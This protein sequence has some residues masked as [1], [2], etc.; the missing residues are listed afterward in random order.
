MDQKKNK[1]KADSVTEMKSQNEA[2]FDDRLKSQI[3][4]EPLEISRIIPGGKNSETPQNEPAEA[5]PTKDE[6]PPVDVEN[7]DPQ[8]NKPVPPK[9]QPEI[10]TQMESGEE[11][12]QNQ[13]NQPDN[14]QSD[15]KD[16]KDD[17]NEDDSNQPNVRKKVT[18]QVKEF[19]LNK[20]KA[21]A[22]WVK[23]N[24]SKAGAKAAARAV[25]AFIA[26][27]WPYI[28]AVLVIIFILI[29][30]SSSCSKT[31]GKTPIHPYDKNTDK[32]LVLKVLASSGDQPSQRE[33]YIL[34]AKEA[35]N[36][37][38]NIS[39]QNSDAQKK[40]D[41]INQLLDEIM[42]LSDSPTAMIEKI[43]QIIALLDQLITLLPD[44]TTKIDAIKT[45]VANIQKM[46]DLYKNP[47]L[48]LNPKDADYIR[49]FE[50][51]RRIGQ[52]LLY[53][54][55]PVDQ[56]G[57]GHERLKVKR[58]KF[59]YDTEN[60]SVSKETDYS[61]EDEPNISAHFT[62]QAADIVEIDN[63][64]CVQIKRRRVGRSKKTNLPP[65]PIKVSWQSE[66]GYLRD[67]GP[68]AYGQNMHQVF[69]NLS[70][71]AIDDVL[72][73]QLSD[74]LG[75]D[76]DPEKIKGKTFPEISR[77][78][79]Q[80]VLKETLGIPGDYKIG[81]NL[82][83][84]A[85]S[86]GRAY[87]ANAMGVPI[88]GI[89]GSTPE[90]ISENI[91]RASL[92]EKM[93]LA[94]GSLEGNNTGE[95]F[96]SA[97]RRLME[98]SLGLSRNTF[99]TAFSDSSSFRKVIGQGKTEASL[100]LKPQTFYGANISEVKTRIGKSSYEETFANP[101]SIDNWLGI[102]TG[103]TEK[104]TLGQISPD[105]YNQLVGNHLYDAQI[106]IY[107][108]NNKRAEVFGVQEADLDALTNGNQGV[109]VSMGKTV[110]SQT[111]TASEDERVLLRQWFDTG[112]RDPKL[113]DDYI[114]GQY[115]LKTGD[116]ADIFINSMGN[117]VF[118]RL[119]RIK[120][121][122][123]LSQNSTSTAL[124]DYVEVVQD[125]VFYTDRLNLI[126][127]DLRYLE[128]ES[129][130][131]EVR[132]KAKETR[133]LVENL[134]SSASITKIKKDIKQIQAN[135]K[136][137]E[138]KGAK[139]DPESAV[140]IKEIKK[141]V[142]EIIEGK[143]IDD[144]DSLD[145]GT[146]KAKTDPQVKLTKKDVIAIL[147][148]KK[149]VDDLVY[150]IGLRK[151][152]I[153]LDLPDNSL[154]TAY[155][156]L[157]KT[158]FKEA[159]ETTLISIG[160]TRLAE[161]GGISGRK[162][163]QVDKDLN[164]PAG[165]TQAYKDKKITE[166]AYHRK[167]GAGVTNNIAAK[168]LNK[169]LD[170]TN[171]PNYTLNGGDVTKLLS[172]GWFY[173]ALKVGGRGIDEAFSFPPGGTMDIITQTSNPG[174]VVGMIAEK[175]LGLLA[176]LNRSVSINGN[177]S[178]NLGRVKIEQELGLEPNEL[179]DD[180]LVDRIKGYTG[181]D[182]DSLSQLDMAFGLEPSTSHALIEGLIDP[183][184]YITN[185]GI[186]VRDNV[187]YQQIQNYAPALRN[188][189][190]KD[191]VLA[192]ASKTGTP[193][194]I[195]ASAGATQIGQV[196][197]LDY[198]VSIRGNFKDNLG[199]AKVENR[200]GLLKDSFQTDIDSVIALNGQQK[201][202][203]AF[204]ID[205]GELYNAR[206]GD[207]G[208][209]T[210]DRIQN[211]KIVDAILNIPSGY[212]RSFIIGAI[213]LSNYVDQVGKSS[214]TEI[215]ADKLVD[216]FE[217]DDKYK[218]A[219][220]TLVNTLN[221]D[222]DLDS[223][224][225]KQILLGALLTAG[226]WNLD[227]MTRFDPGTWEKI[228]FIDPNDPENTG[229]KNGTKIILEQGKKY[230]PKWMGM[231]EKYEPYIDMIYEQGLEYIGFGQNIEQA[232]A[233]DIKK[234]TG[235]PDNNDAL[236][237]TR[238]D[239][240]GGFTAWGAAQ[241]TASYNKE[242][243]GQADAPKLDYYTVKTAYFNDPA[244][245]QAIG[246]SAVE[247]ARNQPDGSYLTPDIE[248]SIR[249]EAIRSARNNARTNVQY[250][251]VDMQLHKQD[252]NVPAGFTKAMREGNSEARWDMGLKY[253]GNVIHSNNSAIPSE[254][255]P[256]LQDYFIDH[257][258][259]HLSDA[260]YAFLDNFMSDKFGDFIQPGTAKALV[261][262]QQT[263]NFGSINDQGSL[264]QIYA[265]YGVDIVTNWAD[266]QTSLPTGTTKLA[267]DYFTK[268]KTAVET[269][270]NAVTA[271]N[272]AQ[273]AYDAAK[274]TENAKA[275]N[276]AKNAA[277]SS[278]NALNS[279]KANAISTVISYAFQKQLYAAD[280]QLGLVPGSSAMLVGMGVSAWITGAVSPWT[281]ALFVATNLFG[282]YRIDTVCSACGSYP[283]VS[284]SEFGFVGWQVGLVPG[285]LAADQA[286]SL[287]SSQTCPLGNFDGQSNE[288][289]KTNAMAAAQ[290][291]TNQ[292]ISD[293]LQMG[294][295]LKDENLV[296]T[297]IMTYRQDDVDSNAG[298]L[299]ELYG[300]AN[301]RGNSGLWANEL[302]WD[303]VHIGY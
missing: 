254:L 138:D 198:A 257:N 255:L 271:L 278:T 116:F 293:V 140:K 130:S 224:Q 182:I 142:N 143:V 64:K 211:S 287:N 197:G 200:L 263:G 295:V 114:G 277:T 73:D 156:E 124:N 149:S 288:A 10:D 67:G 94:P 210:D 78:I 163:E 265:D 8:M 70:S 12:N 41:E 151:W 80:A 199:A 166:N 2:E 6:K 216:L 185:T 72:I 214:M 66:E 241:I 28:L 144:F 24:V 226:G 120:L 188:K 264:T 57:A 5:A 61:D 157:K 190:V 4:G 266:K 100:G 158:D 81:G 276:D 296:P 33:L 92:E 164:L 95:V 146:I 99:K 42:T 101:E 177:I 51:D 154:Q 71:G 133:L 89:Q 111:A 267:Y 110:I 219:V 109:F 227:N 55:T 196:L 19:Y 179:N 11:N 231:E 170:L 234:V 53:L 192:L 48:I 96:A 245:E 128:N 222:S 87:L 43:K 171:D 117:E 167:I 35:K 22:D 247:Y 249:Q 98:E 301:L 186:S 162:T 17:Q 297:Q 250:S 65:T 74:I 212:T 45:E 303:H 225:N 248:E 14:N 136:Y 181:G 273:K 13:D 118:E 104:L 220:D 7:F 299:D 150:A 145:A 191:A 242:F 77:Y 282:V 180:N 259:D 21:A 183:H 235:I 88:E 203:S 165:T 284:V 228:I 289:F 238:G 218:P 38:A 9:P 20:K 292:V 85:Q 230:L 23:K 127:D 44:Q 213:G 129:P 268:Y 215:T 82:G 201:F 280:Q 59:S 175:K 269:Y 134:L 300:S 251:I 173:V 239:I 274:T 26:A 204:Y 159:D 1:I 161:Y 202:E 97:G 147:T 286:S 279:L 195:L 91:G 139:A 262:Y 233:D 209:W 102:A 155:Q 75:V 93:S 29:M 18:D 49:N 105:A 206:A 160:K 302:M 194:D 252:P 50:G 103:T 291:K 172:G 205:S 253:L 63:I 298:S 258:T 174:D 189:D 141:A 246:D 62:G 294:T 272:T 290:Y 148:G 86:A 152:E 123:N 32:N 69:N 256:E 232:F 47:R 58:I 153:E 243:E 229:P 260:S 31:S 237:F 39:G 30:I 281:M 106:G 169:Q 125:Y 46:I 168:V 221:T 112:T 131:P 187:F 56:G 90:E 60:K 52:M 108:K 261:N 283:Q 84:I 126:K 16:K 208:Y 275:L 236:R 3:E 207:S 113:D 79:G 34:G 137:M 135:L 83:D 115:G 15:K 54:V 25:W 223:D 244:G 184:E 37:L 217:I 121:L 119:G 40:I 176:G 178:Y 107:Q 193:Q 76:L 240:K 270:K 68:D 27:Y 285:M 36:K 132:A 122:D